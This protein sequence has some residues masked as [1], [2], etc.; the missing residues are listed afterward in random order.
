VKLT[1][2]A[3]LETTA[4]QFIFAE[5]ELTRTLVR[6]ATMEYADGSRKRGLAIRAKIERVC[7]EIQ[8][9]LDTAERRGWIRPRSASDS[10]TSARPWRD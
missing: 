3:D 5:L 9:R 6:S 4:Q 7:A 2:C 10:M 8:R 1:H